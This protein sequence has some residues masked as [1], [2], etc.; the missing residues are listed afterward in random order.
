MKMTFRWFSENGD[1]VKLQQIKQIPGMT[2][3]M[4]TLD[5][6]AAGEVWTEEE[7]EEY[8]THVEQSGL[9]CEVIE[10]V[11]VHEDI[12]MGLPT[13]DQYIENYKVTIRNLAKF[14]VKVIVY[15]FMPVFD[16]LRTDLAYV[17]QE[18]GSNCLYYDEKELGN[19]TPIDLVKRTADHSNGFSLPGWEPERLAELET[20][21]EH[22][23]GMTADML[24]EN[25]KYF[26]QQIIPVCEECHVLMAVHPDD[27]AWSVFDLPRIAHSKEDFDKIIHFYDSPCNTICL[28]TGSFGS[29]PENDIVEAIQY[30]G[31][32]NRIGCM[33][34]RNIKYLGYHHFREASHLSTDGDLDLYEIV[35]AIYQYCPSIHV[36]PD[37]GRMI[38]SETGRPGYGLYDRALGATYL[39][40]L[41]EA[42]VKSQKEKMLHV[43]EKGILEKK[44]WEM[45]EVELPKFEIDK[46]KE[47]TKKAPV[48]VHFG[49]GNIFRGFIA[50]LQQKLL[51]QGIEKSGI[52]AADTF[53]FDIIDNIYDPFDNMTMFVGMRPDGT[54]KKEIVASIG[55]AYRASYQYEKDI[56]RLKEIF[57]NP[58]LQMV[59][60]T[61]TEKGYALTDMQG[62]LFPY[63]EKDLNQG[64]GQCLHAMSILTSLL[65]ERFQAGAVPIAIVSMDNCSH[66]GEKLRDSVM[67][68]VNAWAARNFVTSEFVSWI[69]NEEMVSFPWTM[70]DKIT[71][72]PSGMVE[73]A[74]IELGIAD[75]EPI[76]TN[77]NTYIAPFVN[78]EEPQYLVVEDRFP[79]GRPMLE[80]AGVYMTDRDTVND[81][82]RMKVTTC[83]NPLHT[84]LA[85]FGCMLGYESIAAEMEDAELKKL[86]A[87]IGL[88]E[89]MPV[90]TDPGIIHPKDFIQEVMEKRLPNPY[91]PDTPQRIATDTSQKMAIRFGETIKS[92][93]QNEKLDTETLTAIPLVIAGWFRYLLGVDDQ[94]KEYTC[95]SDPML[96]LLQEKLKG[97]EVGNSKVQEEVLQEILSNKVLF[98]ID[99]CE[100]G[101]SHKI[102]QMLQEMLS[103][104]G[105]IRNTLQKYLK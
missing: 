98:G 42:V 31:E 44:A 10:S 93:V 94:G 26:L 61:I 9:S 3:I 30:F 5:Y 37:H 45:A 92:Y 39:N 83:L 25:Y 46:M 29:D 38:W 85:I 97:M 20:T 49:A 71:P 6:K 81:T 15:N 67:Q 18:D 75:M 69:A 11:N 91:I 32:R 4:G 21:L 24:R 79:N 60:F 41:W 23:K 102:I 103:G 40:G 50:V 22:Y 52:V 104:K 62:K 63:V 58:T 19:M 65:L 82:E 13:R 68:I 57:R 1:S 105:A 84:A 89:G 47:S 101:M 87:Q 100:I 14:G 36:R 27:P 86:V 74:L 59:S 88:Q 77:K 96:S 90:V 56:E 80:K 33:H 76:V 95:S 55:E 8:I 73:K 2:G 7:I 12:K 43:N 54:L 17:I 48:W 16:W 51:N 72:R 34:I 28:C 99:L 35:K 70:I 64:P 53:D 78:A 66:N